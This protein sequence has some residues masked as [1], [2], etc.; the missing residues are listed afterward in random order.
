M[1]EYE[2]REA[3]GLDMGV[4]GRVVDEQFAVL[5]LGPARRSV[6]EELCRIDDI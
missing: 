6:A 4:V 3:M 1:V 2:L 5:I